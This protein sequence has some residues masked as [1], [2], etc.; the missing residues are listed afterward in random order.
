MGETPMVKTNVSKNLYLKT[1]SILWLVLL[2]ITPQYSGLCIDIKAAAIETAA[3]SE[4]ET[5]CP[6]SQAA[7]FEKFNLLY[8]KPQD[9]MQK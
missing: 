4:L 2:W 1:N 9:T 5:T 6:P 7:S 3:I 8:Q